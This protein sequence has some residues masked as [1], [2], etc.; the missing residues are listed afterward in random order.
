MSEVFEI[1]PEKGFSSLLFGSSM[2]DAEQIFGKPEEVVFIDDIDN[3]P[4]T[5]WHYWE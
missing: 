1:Q 5:V 3:Y 2:K 4:T